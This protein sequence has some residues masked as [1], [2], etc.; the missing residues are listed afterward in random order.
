[1]KRRETARL[2]RNHEDDARVRIV[3][4]VRVAVVRVQPPI[5]VVVIDSEDLEIVVGVRLCAM[6]SLP[7]PIEYSLSCILSGI[8]MP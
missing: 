5:V 2:A 3:Q 6:L 7:L 4:V 1:M 8:F